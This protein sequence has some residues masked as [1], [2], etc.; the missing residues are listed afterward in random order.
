MP[1]DLTSDLEN[2]RRYL[3]N[4]SKF[5]LDELAR[6]AGQWVAWSSDGAR[7]VAHATAPEALDD[8]IRGAG[9]DPEQCLIEGIPAEDA[10]IG[11]GYDRNLRTE[12]AVLGTPRFS[13]PRSGSAATAG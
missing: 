2:R 1:P 12:S 13:G 5:P 3:E 6:Y 8:L 10:M 4:R 9:E 7:I 11:G